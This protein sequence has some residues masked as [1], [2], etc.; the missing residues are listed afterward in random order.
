MVLENVKC[1]VANCRYW[2]NIC[3]MLVAIEVNV[4]GGENRLEILWKPNVIPLNKNK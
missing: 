4:D 3:V 2:Q 1:S